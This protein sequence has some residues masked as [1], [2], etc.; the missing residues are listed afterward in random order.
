MSLKSNLAKMLSQEIGLQEDVYIHS[1]V[2]TSKM[3]WGPIAGQPHEKSTCDGT[4][5]ECTLFVNE[6]KINQTKQK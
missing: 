3:H 6:P 1:V 4:L 2:P 5:I